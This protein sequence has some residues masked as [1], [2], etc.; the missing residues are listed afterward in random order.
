M[1]KV[2]IKKQLLEIGDRLFRSSKKGQRKKNGKRHKGKGMLIFS[3]ILVVYL[4]AMIAAGAWGTS[5][6]LYEVGVGWL[7]FLLF[8]GVAILLGTLGSVFNTYTTLY[9]SKDND[10][11][12]SMPI[13]IRDVILSRLLGVY[14]T[15]LGY[16]AVVSLPT[17]V[18]GWIRGGVSAATLVGGVLWIFVLSLIV[19]GLSCLL[20]WV[21]ARLSQRLKNKS[22]I[23]VLIGLVMIGLYYFVYFKVMSRLDDLLE[24]VLLIGGKIKSSLYPIYLFGRFPEGDWLAM[25]A[26][27]G[28]VLLALALIWFLLQHSFLS[29]ATSSAVGKHAV[30][31]EKKSKQTSVSSALLRREWYRFSGSATY[32][33]NC[34]LGV[35]FLL[36]GGI[37]L[38]FA[39][40]DVPSGVERLS[41]LLLPERM[42][43]VLPVFFGAISAMLGSLVTI[44]APSVS[45]EG[46]T[47]WQ[48]QSLP[49]EPWQILQAKLRLH[50]AVA[51]IPS[52]FCFLVITVLVPATLAQKLLVFAIGVLFT[53]FFALFGLLMG[54]KMPNLGWKNETAAVKQSGA[55]AISML[56]SMCLTIAFGGLYFW[57]GW[58]IGATAYLGIAALLLLA[59]NA[60]MLAWLHGPGTR[61]FAELSA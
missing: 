58:R 14:I 57:F 29:V 56:A 59:A 13:P 23:T 10:L 20:G 7:Y 18:V 28:G 49:V 21:V 30:Y 51:A 39:G 53:V 3:L 2:L 8:G 26:W 60:A 27:T 36:A 43:G 34:G 19:F 52:L 45:L 11:L 61:R 17:V 22:F 32:M 42:K 41:E 9:L 37:A 44:T 47:L 50:L 24:N 4:L 38:L 33:L 46:K 1:L 15:G 16:S 48:I 40:K 12:L 55:V 5:G 54:V 6:P 25:L 35:V 31:R